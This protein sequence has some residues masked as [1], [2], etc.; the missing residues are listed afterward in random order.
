MIDEKRFETTPV[1][2]IRTLLES[3]KDGKLTITYYD[4]IEPS[5]T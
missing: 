4:P 2:H 1:Q 5:F 3:I